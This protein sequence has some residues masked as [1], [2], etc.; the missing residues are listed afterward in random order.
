MYKIIYANKKI[1]LSKLD[2]QNT[3]AEKYSQLK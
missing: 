1:T 3:K 2:I